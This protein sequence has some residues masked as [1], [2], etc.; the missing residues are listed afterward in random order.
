MSFNKYAIGLTLG[1]LSLGANASSVSGTMSD[2]TAKFNASLSIEPFEIEAGAL[3][4]SDGG[5]SGYVGAMI[6]DKADPIEVGVGIRARAVEGDLGAGDSGYALGFGGYYRYILPQANRVSLYGSG[7]YYPSLF[8]YG[9]IKRQHEADFRAEYS[10]TRN[11]RV[12]VSYS[13]VK[14]EFADYRDKYTLDEG[15][16]FGVS[17]YF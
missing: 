15:I 9:D 13:I 11:A 3:Y 12:Y 5:K 14:T 6:V 7:Y 17:A 1:L 8:S 4:L 10:A 16:N 2:T